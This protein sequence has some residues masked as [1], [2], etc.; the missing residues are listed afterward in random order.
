MSATPKCSHELIG[1]EE[2]IVAS[3]VVANYTYW[4]FTCLACGAQSVAFQKEDARRMFAET[5]LTERGVA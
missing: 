1:A 2:H 5:Y 3:S 4:T